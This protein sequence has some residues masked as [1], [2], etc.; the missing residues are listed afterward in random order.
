MKLLLTKV[1]VDPDSKDSGYGHCCRG[2][3]SMAMKQ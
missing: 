1:S 3:Q 2:R